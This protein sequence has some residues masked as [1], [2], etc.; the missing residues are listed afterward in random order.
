MVQGI[1]K[2]IFWKMVPSVPVHYRYFPQL[3]LFVQLILCDQKAD[4]RMTIPIQRGNAA[5][6]LDTF[7]DD[8][9]MVWR[10]TLTQI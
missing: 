6:L 1:M 2:P 3:N 7:P 10:S 9:C 5:I 4:Q 8:S